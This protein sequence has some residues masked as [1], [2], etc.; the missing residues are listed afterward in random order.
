ML[1]SSGASG[2][3]VDPK[4]SSIPGRTCRLCGSRT[5]SRTDR[6]VQKWTGRPSDA[7]GGIRRSES[8]V[9]PESR[10]AV[11]T[12]RHGP[13]DRRVVR[14]VGRPRSLSASPFGRHSPRT[15]FP[16]TPRACHELHAPRSGPDDRLCGPN[17][18]DGTSAHPPKSRLELRS[19]GGNRSRERGPHPSW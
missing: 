6:I 4:R 18:T 10:P 3:P 14:Q 19:L 8:C 15:P 2:Q 16:T 11:L 5:R 12:S 7:G 13:S 17:L 1:S 9:A